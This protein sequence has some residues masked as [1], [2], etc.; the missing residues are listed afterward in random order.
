LGSAGAKTGG[1]Q[2]PVDQTA[3]PPV[4]DAAF[5]DCAPSAPTEGKRENII[6]IMVIIF[7]YRFEGWCRQREC[8][9]CA[10]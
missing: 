5:D 6:D 2:A 3:Q 9:V 4:F 10:K 1:Y 8:D 7:S